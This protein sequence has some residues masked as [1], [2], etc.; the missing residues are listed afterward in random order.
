[1]TASR[2]SGTTG[3]KVLASVLGRRRRRTANANDAV[4]NFELEAGDN[5]L[6]ENGDFLLLET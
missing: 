2:A 1:M 3:G 4:S 6:L 5:V